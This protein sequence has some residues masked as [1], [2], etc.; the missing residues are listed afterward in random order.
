MR[1]D[2]FPLTCNLSQ[3]CDLGVAL[4]QTEAVRGLTVWAEIDSKLV[5]ISLQQL[6]HT[7]TRHLQTTYTNGGMSKM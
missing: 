5:L 2:I 6:S 1:I 3:N 4:R 7:Y